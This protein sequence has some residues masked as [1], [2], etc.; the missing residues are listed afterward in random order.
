MVSQLDAQQ[1]HAQHYLEVARS[2]GE[3]YRTGGTAAH[4]ALDDYDLE[5]DNIQLGQQWAANWSQQN[6]IA[7]QLVSAYAQMASSYLN[8][9]RHPRERMR[10][11]EQALES[12]RHRDRHWAQAVHLLTLATAYSDVGEHGRAIRSV[13]EALDIFREINH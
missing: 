9:R 2:L 5:W 4:S 12:A 7:A 3:R 1:R 11:A 6:E 8:V 10:W 13:Q